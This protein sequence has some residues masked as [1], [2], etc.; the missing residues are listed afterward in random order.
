MYQALL[1]QEHGFCKQLDDFSR[2]SHHT[3][4]TEPAANIIRCD[5]VTAEPKYI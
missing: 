5:Y 2:G 4:N 3:E 1:Y